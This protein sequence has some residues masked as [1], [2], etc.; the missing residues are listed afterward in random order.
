MV[1]RA[2]GSAS[3]LPITESMRQQ[4]G[5]AHR[6][7]RLAHSWA[8]A[9]VS[10][11]KKAGHW[12][13]FGEA[14]NAQV[15]GPNI[16]EN[17]SK[18]SRLSA[19]S[20][21]SKDN[22]GKTGASRVE[23]G[24]AVARDAR[25]I[26]RRTLRVQGF[27]VPRA[28]RASTCAQREDDDC[29]G[30]VCNA[31]VPV[32]GKR[33]MG[34]SGSGQAMAENASVR[35]QVSLAK[36]PSLG[37]FVGTFERLWRPSRAREP[38]PSAVGSVNKPRR[39]SL[40]G[41]RVSITSSEG[42]T[43]GLSW[44]GDRGAVTHS[45]EGARAPTSPSSGPRLVPSLVLSACTPTNWSDSPH[46][47][48]I[49]VFLVP[50]PISGVCKPGQPRGAPHRHFFFI[51]REGVSLWDP[52]SLGRTS[53]DV[54][55]PNEV[56]EH[57]ILRGFDR[58]TPTWFGPSKSWEAS[59]RP[60]V[61][62]G[63]ILPRFPWRVFLPFDAQANI[64]QQVVGTPNG[65]SARHHPEGS[66]APTGNRNAKPGERKDGNTGHAHEKNRIE[67]RCRRCHGA[68]VQPPR[69]NAQK[70]VNLGLPQASHADPTGKANHPGPGKL[71]SGITLSNQQGGMTRRN[72]ERA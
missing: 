11:V 14:N 28:R 66:R 72:G 10:R 47:R 19:Y 1:T 58:W 15:N 45:R 27:G 13:L 38:Q 35:V 64:H 57:S 53:P 16:I 22:L 44:N 34:V 43:S 41:K 51:G 6:L 8:R 65:T 23:F 55:A 52:W 24:G 21:L 39:T 31:N 7:P 60:R 3:S 5:C 42:P 25:S 12:A 49:L 59:S 20:P 46:E 63:W 62:W 67:K 50:F 71:R 4:G 68:H 36:G 18:A 17:L 40:V 48:F 61:F 70:R 29:D 56:V 54:D 26:G 69:Q 37:G 2:L 33:R 32:P 30:G 9:W